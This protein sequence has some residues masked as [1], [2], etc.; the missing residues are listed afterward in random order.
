MGAR[1]AGHED[2]PSVRYP[3]DR[4]RTPA[5]HFGNISHDSSA[6]GR[7]DFRNEKPLAVMTRHLEKG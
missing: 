6:C 7:D 1:R 4:P 2:R 3:V 5:G